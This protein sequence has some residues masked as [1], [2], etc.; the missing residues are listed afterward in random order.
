MIA[1]LT[2]AYPE[3]SFFRIGVWQPI[4]AFDAVAR[5]E[6]LPVTTFYPDLRYFTAPGAD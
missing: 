2:A 1:A 5:V 6:P 4:R 3:H